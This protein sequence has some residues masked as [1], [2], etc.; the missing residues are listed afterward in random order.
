MKER[1]RPAQLFTA[2]VA[3]ES[4]EQ[5]TLI[6]VRFFDGGAAKQDRADEELRGKIRDALDGEAEG[7]SQNKI[8]LAVKCRK[9]ELGRQLLAMRQ[10]G[11]VVENAGLRGAKLY[12]LA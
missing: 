11:E 6:A 5:E 10:L 2:L 9:N 1:N 3:L 12:R 7:L 4:D 8:R